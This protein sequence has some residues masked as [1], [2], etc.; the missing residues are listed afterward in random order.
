MYYVRN[1]KGL[2]STKSLSLISF[3]N[4]WCSNYN[5]NLNN[6]NDCANKIALYKHNKD[7]NAFSIYNLYNN[8][9]LSKLV[10][11]YGL[12]NSSLISMVCLSYFKFISSFHLLFNCEFNRLNPN[13][14]YLNE[15]Y[16]ND[17]IHINVKKCNINNLKDIDK[18]KT[19]TNTLNFNNLKED[20]EIIYNKDISFKKDKNKL[21]FNFDTNRSFVLSNN[22]NKSKMYIRENLLRIENKL[23][24]KK[25]HYDYYNSLNVNSNSD[26]YFKGYKLL[27]YYDLGFTILCLIMHE[28]YKDIDVNFYNNLSLFMINY[29][30]IHKNDAKCCCLYHC[31]EIKCK[32]LNEENNTSFVLNTLISYINSM[33]DNEFINFLCLCLNYYN[34]VDYNILVENS[35]SLFEDMNIKNI[36][37]C[38]FI[39]KNSNLKNESLSIYNNIKNEVYASYNDIIILI[40]YGDINYISNRLYSILDNNYINI[41]RY[42]NLILKIE[43]YLFNDG[44]IKN[45]L[46]N[47]INNYINNLNNNKNQHENINKYHLNNFLERNNKKLI[48]LLSNE[49]QLSYSIVLNK[50]A[51][52]ILKAFNIN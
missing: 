42:D 16:I 32:N 24:N 2:D 44:D 31:L 30:C 48:L 3:I 27:D 21:F 33:F 40:N 45:K 25:L 39:L 15:K 1:I 19:T 28:L 10:N 4:K 38:E 5:L 23:I 34:S 51:D 13:F 11:D 17:N 52:I 22:N 26:K 47:Q 50:I 35:Y 46:K 43:R 6:Y 29:T 41:K 12:I 49:Y 18:F 37:T 14:V 20:Q 7:L 36:E 8:I 9:S